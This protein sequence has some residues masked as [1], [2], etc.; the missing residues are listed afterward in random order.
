M[1]ITTLT[2]LLLSL[3]FTGCEK[4]IGEDIGPIL[5]T[6]ALENSDNI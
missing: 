6:A 2:A 4:K 5:S 1:K 3:A